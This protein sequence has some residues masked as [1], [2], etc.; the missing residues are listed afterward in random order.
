MPEH[1]LTPQI[2]EKQPF[3]RLKYKRKIG[4]ISQ[5]HLCHISSSKQQQNESLSAPVHNFTMPVFPSSPQKGIIALSYQPSVVELRRDTRGKH[6]KH[7]GDK[8]DGR[9]GKASSMRCVLHV[10]TPAQ[11][12]HCLF[13]VRQKQARITTGKSHPLVGNKQAVS[14]LR[15]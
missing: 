3:F 14:S 4:L 13:G 5:T 12:I 1:P 6:G 2:P 15:E 8:S 9:L 11:T 10:C 7:H